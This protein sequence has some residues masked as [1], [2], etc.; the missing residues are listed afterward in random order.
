MHKQAGEHF[1]RTP[2]TLVAEMGR[3]SLIGEAR[4]AN[5]DHFIG[6]IGGR[7]GTVERGG[8]QHVEVVDM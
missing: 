8:G 5:L 6:H 4:S 3:H 2:L 7:R 1:T